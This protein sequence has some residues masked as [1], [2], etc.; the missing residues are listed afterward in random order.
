MN[1]CFFSNTLKFFSA[2]LI[3]VVLNSFNIKSQ[4]NNNE[5]SGISKSYNFVFIRDGTSIDKVPV[6]A[7][8]KDYTDRNLELWLVKGEFEK[9]IDYNNRLSEESVNQKIIELTQ[10]AENAY[11]AEYSKTINWSDFKLSQ[12]DADNEKYN[13]SSPKYGSFTIHVPISEAPSLKQ[14]WDKVFFSD[15][16]FTVSNNE[17]KITAIKIKNVINGISYTNSSETSASG[18]DNVGQNG[19]PIVTKSATY[20]KTVNFSKI[21]IST[22]SYSELTDYKNE[23]IARQEYGMAKT[24]QDELLKRESTGNFYDI[25]SQRLEKI[26]EEAVKAEDFNKAAKIQDELDKRMK[27]KI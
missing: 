14:N 9:T 13:I 22:L 20:I 27:N 4:G 12:Y 1:C 10:E 24:I 17:I 11:L 26:L 3:I 18:N 2:S 25:P 19:N 23:A 8:V 21:E 6:T 15:S 16:R 5:V 7:F